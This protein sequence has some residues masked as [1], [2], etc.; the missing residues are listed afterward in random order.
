MPGK[1]TISAPTFGLGRAVFSARAWPAR[2][3]SIVAIDLDPWRRLELVRSSDA[4]DAH[5]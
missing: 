5:A 4:V 3:A 2:K 1:I